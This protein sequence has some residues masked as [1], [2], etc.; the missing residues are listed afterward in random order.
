[1]DNTSVFQTDD[2]GSIPGTGSAGCVGK[3]SRWSHTPCIRVRVPYPQFRI[4]LCRGIQAGKVCQI[5][6]VVA[7]MEEHLPCKQ[8]AAGSKPVGS[9]SPKKLIG[10]LR[11]GEQKMMYAMVCKQ[12]RKEEERFWFCQ[13]RYFVMPASAKQIIPVTEEIRKDE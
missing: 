10:K 12:F 6:G 3:V 7:Q 8:K 4:A 11:K 5:N 9:I 13:E 2:P 1:M